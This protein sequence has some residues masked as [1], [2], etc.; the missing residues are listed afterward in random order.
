MFYLMVILLIF[1]KIKFTPA[2]ETQ[3]IH[4][5]YDKKV[6]VDDVKNEVKTI[7]LIFDKIHLKNT[8]RMD[9]T[10]HSNEFSKI[11]RDFSIIIPNEKINQ[12]LNYLEIN[13]FSFTLNEFSK[14]LQK[15]KILAS[16]ISSE[17]TINIFYKLKDIIY[18]LGGEEFF[19]SKNPKEN[20]TLSKKKF[21][22]MLKSKE[23]NVNYTEEILEAVF[24]FLTKTDRN[25]TIEEFRKHF[26]D[27]K[28][29]ELSDE[30]ENKAID[31]INSK[32]VKLS[33]KHNEYYDQLLLKK[34]YRVDNNLSRLDLHRV[35]NL[36]GYGFTAEEI[37]F[38]FKRMDY[39]KDGII[40][41]EEFLKFVMKV[42][43]AL[44]KIKDLIKREN[45]EIEDLLYKMIIDRKKNK[46][47]KR[48]DFLNFKLS[49]FI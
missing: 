36:D 1:N 49:I 2:N 26:K 29:N 21:I 5:V 13:P 17:D 40:D 16:E 24:D 12:L 42:H 38:I 32:I 7:K 28:K 34:L 27:T 39:K 43:D 41:R 33:L 3:K 25:L 11:L 15:C 48:F 14:A 8:T 18:T 46:E 22:N 45:L 4:T 10:I 9:Q 47:M 23:V 6:E 19:F 31:L 35:F 20:D 30:F 37:D 44:Y